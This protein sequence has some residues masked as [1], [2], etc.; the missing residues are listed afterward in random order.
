M[1]M[2]ECKAENNHGFASWYEIFDLKAFCASYENLAMYR[3]G[4]VERQGKLWNLKLV[5]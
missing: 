3:T 1:V 2:L 5:M 4:W